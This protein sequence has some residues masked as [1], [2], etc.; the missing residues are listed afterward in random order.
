MIQTIHTCRKCGSTDI[1]KNGHS[2][3]GSQQYHCKNCR[4]YLVLDPD[5][6]EYSEAEKQRILQAYILQ[7]YRERGSKSAISR[8]F[9]VSRNTLSRW[10]KKGSKK[11]RKAEPVADQV[12]PPEEGDVL[13]KAMSLK[14]RCP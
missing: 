14:R 11:G 7:A 9:G 4:A 6:N 3:S 5:S 8:I 1:V 12:E 2:A 13:E 10:L